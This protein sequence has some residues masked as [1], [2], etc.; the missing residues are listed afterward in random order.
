MSATYRSNSSLSP[1]PTDSIA[2]QGFYIEVY[3]INSRKTVRFKAILK[4]YNDM[5]NIIYED[6]F[7]VGQSEPIKKW[8]S[9]VRQI[10]LSFVALASGISEGRHNLAKVSLLTNMLYSEQD[11]DPSTGYV[12]KVGGSPIFRV[13]LLN[14]IG[15]PEQNWGDAWASGLQ[16]YISNL[17]YRMN[18]DSSTFFHAPSLQKSAEAS[19]RTQPPHEK[20]KDDNHHVYPQEINISFTFH[21]VYERSPAWINGV[22]HVNGKPA[23]RFPYGVNTESANVQTP[24]SKKP[25]SVPVNT[26]PPVNADGTPPANPSEDQP[27]AAGATASENEQPND[28]A[29]A[30][31][32]KTLCAI[33]KDPSCPIGTPGYIP[34]AGE[35]V[36]KLREVPVTG[37]G[38]KIVHRQNKRPPGTSKFDWCVQQHMDH[39]SNPDEKSAKHH[40]R[41]YRGT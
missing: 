40:C 23:G 37:G 41:S 36:S 29:E 25:P 33:S 2:M 18:P 19:G 14:L 35:P 32:L 26:T 5:H 7:F 11:F 28:A 21:P 1:D 12:T 16:G 15:G 20:V 27:A 4:D 10:D 6:Q 9:T 22:F 34:P 31:R 13:R 17:I 38:D 30:E 24:K 39:P 3:H 8:K